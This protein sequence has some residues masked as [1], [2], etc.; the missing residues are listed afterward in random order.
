M[1]ID[2]EIIRDLLPLYAEQM[3]S[4]KSDEVIEEHLKRCSECRIIYKN[5]KKDKIRPEYKDNNFEH[6][7]KR[8]KETQYFNSCYFCFYNNCCYTYDM[9]T[10]HLPRR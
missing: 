9:G 3:T 6:F 8:N 10:F 7:K 5:I 4:A 2:C 1:E